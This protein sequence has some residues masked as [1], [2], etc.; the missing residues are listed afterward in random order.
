MSATP[1]NVSGWTIDT[2]AVHNEALRVAEERLRAGEEKFQHERDRRYAEVKS[3]EEKALRVKEQADRDA[4][5][6]AREIQIYKD[7]KANQLREQINSERGLY[8]TKSDLVAMSDKIEAQI[9]PVLVFMAGTQGR[10][11]GVDANRN[12]IV[13]FVGLIVGL[14][15]IGTFL[16]ITLRQPPQPQTIY[17]PAPAGTTLPVQP[18]AQVPR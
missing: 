13:R 8:A 10:T 12:E 6:L 1:R 4:L 15:A 17:V 3:A 14:I 9:R 7:E 2:Y 5:G 18:P 16:F 11:V